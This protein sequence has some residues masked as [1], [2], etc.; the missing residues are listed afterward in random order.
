MKDVIGIG[1]ERLLWKSDPAVFPDIVCSLVQIAF[2]TQ[3]F[4]T[5]GIPRGRPANDIFI[6]VGVFYGNGKVQV[7]S[8][9]QNHCLEFVFRAGGGVPDIK[10]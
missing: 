1:I 7:L 9:S 3:H 6:V 5:G 8:F 2:K 4:F 10:G